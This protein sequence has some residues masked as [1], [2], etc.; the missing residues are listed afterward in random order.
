VNFPVPHGGRFVLFG[1]DYRG[2]EF[3]AGATLT[4]RATFSDGTTATATTTVQAPPA[5]SVQYN[6]KLR[7]R[8]GQ[9]HTALAADGAMDGTLTVTLSATG[10]RTITGLRL[11]S[12][13]PGTWDTNSATT[14]WALAVAA[15]VD[16]AL[17]N[18]PAST[19]V[20]F[21]VPH[22]GRFVLFASD[23]RSIEFAAGATLTVRATFSD[24]MTATATTTVQAPP[25]LSVQ[26]NGKLRDRVGPG[27]TAL[28]AD[29][30]MDGTLTVTLSATGGR[31]ITGLRLESTGPG[32][33]DTNGATTFWALAVAATVDGPLLNNPSSTAVN[34][35]VS[36]GGRFVLFASDYRSIEFATG[37]TLT[38]RATFSDGTTA[39]GTVTRPS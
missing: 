2:I 22:G 3:A 20:N 4:V 17:L 33:W 34:F 31:T 13:G 28:S 39:T 32:T 30:A 14:F 11:E 1:S 19:A 6:G 21:P 15:T 36:H 23:Y 37:A 12:T 29:G 24:G 18:N 27:N 5:L 16:G 7:D 8:V 26:Y 9:G 10:G 25:A 35:P 38:V